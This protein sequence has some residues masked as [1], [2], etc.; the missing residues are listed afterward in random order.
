MISYFGSKEVLRFKKDIM[1]QYFQNSKT[2][3]MDVNYENIMTRYYL[4]RHSIWHF[5]SI[6]KYTYICIKISTLH[7]IHFGFV[8][9]NNY[10]M[11]NICNIWLD[12]MR[13]II[14]ELQKWKYC[15]I[16]TLSKIIQKVFALIGRHI[17]H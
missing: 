6:N 8:S 2:K 14:W 7:L 10:D 4:M 13:N 3:L 16:K 15:S 12:L 1:A 9:K 17:W 5:P 11:A